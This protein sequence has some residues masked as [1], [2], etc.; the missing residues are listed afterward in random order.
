MP[1]AYNRTIEKL[2]YTFEN[3]QN[4]LNAI[5]KDGKKIRETARSFKIPESTLRKKLGE[6]VVKSPHLGCT[7]VFSS[8]IGQELKEY[9]LLLQ[10]LWNN[11][12]KTSKASI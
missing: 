2:S 11:T 10:I 7:T 3:L 12:S 5:K 8:K 6:D 9:I 1:R 4:A